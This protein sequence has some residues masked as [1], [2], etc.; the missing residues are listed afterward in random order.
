MDFKRFLKN[1]D[2][3]NDVLDAA[4]AKII[5]KREEDNVRLAEKFVGKVHKG[6]KVTATKRL[7]SGRVLLTVNW[8]DESREQ[9]VVDENI[10]LA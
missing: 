4:T 6:G 5:A 3:V 8:D 10:Y 9:F 2:A 7:S 1:L